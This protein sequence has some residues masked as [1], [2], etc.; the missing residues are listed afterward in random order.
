[1][2]IPE[3]FR[4]FS[5]HLRIRNPNQ[6]PHSQLMRVE[7]TAKPGGPKATRLF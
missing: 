3:N 6:N 5:F 7:L 2:E 4:Q 1:M